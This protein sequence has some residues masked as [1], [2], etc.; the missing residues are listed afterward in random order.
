VNVFNDY[1]YDKFQAL[2]LRFV[3]AAASDTGLLGRAQ[4]AEAAG[5]R[6]LQSC[7]FSTPLTRNTAEA[8]WGDEYNL[9]LTGATSLSRPFACL[10][11]SGGSPYRVNAD[12]SLATKVKKWLTWNLAVSDHYLSDPAPAAT[13][14]LALH[15]GDR[16]NLRRADAVVSFPN[17]LSGQLTHD[18]R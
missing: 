18:L 7:S 14:R 2:N 11:P 9:K 16:S 4:F 6:R 12:L 8:Y 15:Y 1:E 5:R 17:S 10:T 13:Q 3:L